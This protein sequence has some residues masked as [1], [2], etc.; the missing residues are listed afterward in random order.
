MRIHPVLIAFCLASCSASTEQS[1]PLDMKT[2][3][4]T[5]TSKKDVERK[6]TAQTTPANERKQSKLIAKPIYDAAAGWGYDIFDGDKLVVHQPHIP[7]IQG[8][9][10]FENADE[11]LLVATKVIE[12]IDAGIMPPSLTKE[13]LLQLGVKLP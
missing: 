2:V 13:E 3:E 10:G 8:N 1:T 7:A 6:T 12:K 11:A 5:S 9:Y 4:T